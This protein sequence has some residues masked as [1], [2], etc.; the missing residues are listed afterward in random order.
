MSTKKIIPF[1][2]VPHNYLSLSPIQEK[3]SE[4]YEALFSGIHP[5]II[6]ASNSFPRI[7]MSESDHAVVLKVELPSMNKDEVTLNI[8]KNKLVIGGERKRKAESDGPSY[9]VTEFYYGNFTRS[10]PFLFDLDADKIQ[11][12]LAHGVLTITVEKPNTEK[13]KARTIP[14]T[15]GNG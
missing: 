2:H 15:H 7:N 10:I 9:H 12:S 13:G 4:F 5:A 8:E 3:M 11:A 14:I 6:N 1:R